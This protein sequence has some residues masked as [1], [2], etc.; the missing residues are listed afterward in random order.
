MILFAQVAFPDEVK[1]FD[2][3]MVWLTL[4]LAVSLIAEIR[5]SIPSISPP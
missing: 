4:A 1:V 3:V 2:L 5:L